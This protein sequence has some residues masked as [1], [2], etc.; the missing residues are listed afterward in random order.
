MDVESLT[1]ILGSFLE[2]IQNQFR[3]SPSL[4]SILGIYR[5]LISI[6]IMHIYHTIIS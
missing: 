4:K 6:L 1:I 2:H 3:T 5:I